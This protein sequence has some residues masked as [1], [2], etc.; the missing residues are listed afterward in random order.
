MHLSLTQPTEAVLHSTAALRLAEPWPAVPESVLFI[1]SRALRA[2]GRP[3][4]AAEFLA[5][6]YRIVEQVAEQIPDST[7]RQSWLSNVWVNREITHDWAAGQP[8][9]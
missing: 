4:E 3:A 2:A 7:L 6:A 8:R 5:R 1:H 9:D